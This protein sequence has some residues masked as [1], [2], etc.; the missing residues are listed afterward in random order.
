MLRHIELLAAEEG[1]SCLSA[2]KRVCRGPVL[3][4]S[5]RL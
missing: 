2:L 3:A 5:R 1:M 4:V